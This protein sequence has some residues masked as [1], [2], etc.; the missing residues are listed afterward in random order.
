[1]CYLVVEEKWMDDFMVL[2]VG[3]KLLWKIFGMLLVEEV[4]KL[5][6]VLSGGD[7]FLFC[8][9]VILELFYLSGLCVMEL[10][11]INI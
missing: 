7:V 4:D 3:L 10:S 2:F 1:M 5:F 6:V 9:K 11:E 8:D